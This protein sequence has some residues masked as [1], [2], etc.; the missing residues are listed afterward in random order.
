MTHPP[1]VPFKLT[2][3]ALAAA[4]STG[5]AGVSLGAL[6][7]ATA[8]PAAAETA[9][10]PTAPTT[11]DFKQN[12]AFSGTFEVA[13]ARLALERSQ[14]Q[15]VKDFAQRMV[16]D[17]TAANEELIVRTGLRPDTLPGATGIPG[18]FVSPEQA[19]HYQQLKD[20]QGADFDRTYLDQQVDAHRQAVTLFD[21]YAKY[22]DNWHMQKFAESTL[23]TLRT[24]LDHAQKLKA[25]LPAPAPQPAAGQAPGGQA[26]G[27]Q[28]PGGQAPAGQPGT[29][30]QPR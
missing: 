27:G 22:G 16:T 3:L 26:P 18:G 28:A 19:A 11:P 29:P 5:A 1:I 17:H 25:G 9:S 20:S 4:L 15:G 2:S 6:A 7:L 23:P 13:S 14:N 10:Q 8:G 21:N 12:A 30:A 24:H